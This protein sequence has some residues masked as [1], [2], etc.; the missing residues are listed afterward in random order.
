MREVVTVSGLCLCCEQWFEDKTEQ[1]DLMEHDLQD[2][3]TSIDLLVANRKGMCVFSS[4]VVCNDLLKLTIM[5]RIVVIIMIITVVI[6]N[7]CNR[8]TN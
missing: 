4:C 7:L 1:L 6:I 5:M 3:H 8:E 2:L